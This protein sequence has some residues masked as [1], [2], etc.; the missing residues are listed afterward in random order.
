MKSTREVIQT[1]RQ[2]LAELETK[3]IGIAVNKSGQRELVL[4]INDGIV[5]TYTI[6]HMLGSYPTTYDESELSLHMF[7]QGKSF[8]DM[9]GD[10]VEYVN[11]L[12]ENNLY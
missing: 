6:S 2:A 9:K 12:K 3:V 11:W 4:T 8:F 7:P 5:I 1:L 10:V